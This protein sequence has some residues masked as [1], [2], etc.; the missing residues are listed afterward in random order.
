MNTRYTKADLERF[1][2]VQLEKLN[3]MHD[4]W[5]IMKVQNELINNVNKKLKEE[6]LD[7]KIKTYSKNLK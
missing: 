4:L 5:S 3:A 1:V 2:S 7:F 6:I